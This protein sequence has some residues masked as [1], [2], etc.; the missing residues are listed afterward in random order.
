[1][2]AGLARKLPRMRR[3]ARRKCRLKEGQ[4]IVAQWHSFVESQHF[5]KR[6]GHNVYRRD[7]TSSTFSKINQNPI[8]AINC[9]DY[10]VQLRHKY[11]Y[12]IVA[13]DREGTREGGR[14]NT[15]QASI[16]RK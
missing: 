6:S 1:M 14:S 9:I 4:A 2:L 3:V 16:P 5:P 12:Y 15:A 8:A 11:F 10:F 7:K 13:A